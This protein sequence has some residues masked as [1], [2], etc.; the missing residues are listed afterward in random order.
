MYNHSKEIAAS[1]FLT[2][3]CVNGESEESTC[4]QKW[5]QRPRRLWRPWRELFWPDGERLSST[6]IFFAESKL[7]L[8]FPKELSAARKRRDEREKRE[9]EE[10]YYDGHGG[11]MIVAQ[12]DSQLLIRPPLGSPLK[13][14]DI[15]MYFP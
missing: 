11:R 10:I 15:S 6:L 9:R 12:T 4:N 2:H 5:L 7:D 1:S 3:I 8:P 14:K 13:S